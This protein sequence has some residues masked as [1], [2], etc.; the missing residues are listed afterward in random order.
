MIYTEEK[1]TILIGPTVVPISLSSRETWE[2]QSY[3]ILMV[4]EHFFFRWRS[5]LQYRLKHTCNCIVINF[6]HWSIIIHNT[7]GESEPRFESSCTELLA[8][9]LQQSAYT[10]W[11]TMIFNYLP[12][13]VQRDL[14]NCVRCFV[15]PVRHF[16]F[17]NTK[18]III[19]YSI[20]VP[21][22]AVEGV[23]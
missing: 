2:L 8:Y 22:L 4:L 18:K 7:D 23:L 6:H 12:C 17:V 20:K 9:I 15:L 21:T 1:K 14:S 19:C 3:R 5:R 13:Y 11:P 16:Q 10:F